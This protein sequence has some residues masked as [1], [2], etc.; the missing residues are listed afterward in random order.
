MII[1]P[2]RDAAQFNPGNISRYQFIKRRGSDNSGENCA[3][4]HKIV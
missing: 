2:L 1:E 3:F 4:Q